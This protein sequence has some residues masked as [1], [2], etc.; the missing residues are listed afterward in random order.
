[1]VGRRRPGRLRERCGGHNQ[2]GTVPRRPR[3]RPLGSQENDRRAPNRPAS[4][5]R[6]IFFGSGKVA[7]PV[8]VPP[9]LGGMEPLEGR[10]RGR[11]TGEKSAAAPPPANRQAESAAAP[12]PEWTA[13]SELAAKLGE[14]QL[15]REVGSVVAAGLLPQPALD[16]RSVLLRRFAELFGP[17]RFSHRRWGQR[18]DRALAR[19]DRYADRGRGRRGAGLDFALGLVEGHAEAMRWEKRL[20]PPGSLAYFV[21][22]LEE[23]SKDWRRTQAHRRS[24]PPAGWRG[25]WANPKKRDRRAAEVK[26]GCA[27]VGDQS[28]GE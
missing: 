15:G 19:L 11:G 7:S 3:R 22:L 21:P 18:L 17:P 5:V 20:S 28:K 12:R 2:P 23:V 1:M 24:E 9:P 8:G 14:Q 13:G 16:A 6:R 25:N 10:S 27:P 4:P 26:G